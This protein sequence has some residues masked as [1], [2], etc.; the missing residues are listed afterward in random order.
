L[1]QWHQ[2]TPLFRIIS[3]ETRTGCNFSCSFCPVAKGRDPRPTSVMTWSLLRRIAR[4]LKALGYSDNIFLYCN[5]EP[6][7]DERLP[8][9]V[10]LFR[11]HCPG[12]RMK[13]LTNGILATPDL[14][15]SLFRCGLSVFEIDNYTDGVRLA[16]PVQKLVDAADRFRSWDIRINMRKRLDV[17]TN[18]GGTAPNAMPRTSP[19]RAFCALPFTD[20]NITPSGQVGLCCFDAL[21]QVVVAELSQLSLV[22]AWVSG[23][24]RRVRNALL[25]KD[26]SITGIC[27]VCDYGGCRTPPNPPRYLHGKFANLPGIDA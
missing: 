23:P 27:A 25:K 15:E 14:V 18:R 2:G 1:S 16:G 8:E 3:I 10:R 26:R 7:L 11:D 24:L 4:Q 20:L 19:L 12:A 6:L 5:N 21:A 17:L 9:L 22:D 13:V